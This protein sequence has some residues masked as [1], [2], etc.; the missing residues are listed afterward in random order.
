MGILGIPKS[1]FVVQCG[2]C[3]SAKAF[4]ATRNDGTEPPDLFFENFPTKGRLVMTNQ[5]FFIAC[6]SCR[7]SLDSIVSEFGKTIMA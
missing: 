5:T 6:W 2:H 7:E 3:A 4:W 1:V